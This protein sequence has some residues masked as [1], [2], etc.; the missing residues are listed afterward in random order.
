M[1]NKFKS[2]A[3]VY[4]AYLA[5]DEYDESL[6]N[7]IQKLGEIRVILYLEDMGPTSKLD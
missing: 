3:R 1:I 4:D 2:F 5:L 7:P 6:E